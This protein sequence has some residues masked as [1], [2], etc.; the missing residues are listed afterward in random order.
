VP[1]AAAA[2]WAAVEDES[3]RRGVRSMLSRMVCGAGKWLS[4]IALQIGCAGEHVLIRTNLVGT[5]CC[6]VVVGCAGIQ[7]YR[8]AT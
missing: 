5:M 4:G 2:D 8:G 6:L 7:F 3:H 1:V